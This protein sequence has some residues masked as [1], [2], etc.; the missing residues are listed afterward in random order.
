[1]MIPAATKRLLRRLADKYETC[2]FVEGDPSCVL[3]KYP[4][5]ADTETAAFI[6]AVLSF[7]RREQFMQKAGYIFS[8]S[9]LRPASWIRSGAWRKDFPRGPEKFYRFYSYND[10]RDVF[11]CLQKILLEEKTFGKY[12]EK[13]YHSAEKDDCRLD[14]LVSSCFPGCRAV[15]HTKQSANKRINMF[16]RWMVRTGSSVDLGLWTWYSPADLIIPLDTHV[17]AVAKELGL[18]PPS[19]AG[20]AKTAAELTGV[21][22]QVWPDDPCHGDFALFGAGIDGTA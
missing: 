22:R 10:M 1:M 13:K 7:G 15:S 14:V 11:S 16:L 3:R 17:L 5:T 4:T 8:L 12:I 6:T 21:L 18:I 19:A 2:C 9:G 20:T